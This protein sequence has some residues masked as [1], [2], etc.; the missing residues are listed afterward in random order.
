[1]DFEFT[2]FADTSTA[3]PPSDPVSAMLSVVGHFR[4]R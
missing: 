1:M 2:R 4:F 3:S